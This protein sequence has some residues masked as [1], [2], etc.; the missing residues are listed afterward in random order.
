MRRASRYRTGV[1]G[2][3]TLL[4]ICLA[5][6]HGQQILQAEVVILPDGGF[7]P[8][9]TTRAQGKFLLVIGNRSQANSITLGVAR[10]DGLSKVASANGVDLN[11]DYLLNLPSASYIVTDSAHPNVMATG[12]GFRNWLPRPLRTFMMRR[13]TWPRNTVSRQRRVELNISSRTPWRVRAW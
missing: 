13:G 8:S 1:L 10:N 2:A 7:S 4:A 3:A 6:L 12:S 11:Q 9:K 5:R